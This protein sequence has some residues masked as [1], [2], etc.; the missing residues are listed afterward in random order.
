MP[1]LNFAM[2]IPGEDAAKDTQNEPY[3]LVQDERE[4]ADNA[5]EN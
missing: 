1:D 5:A 4:Q 3:A 2:L